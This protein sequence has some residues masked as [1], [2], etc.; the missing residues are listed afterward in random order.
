MTISPAHRT[1][2]SEELARRLA[3][4][5]RP[6]P[7]PTQSVAHAA[8]VHATAAREAREALWA[9]ARPGRLRPAKQRPAKRPFACD[10]C[11]RR[12]KT[13]EGR[14]QHKRD[15]HG[16]GGRITAASAP[17]LSKNA[18]RKAAKRFGALSE[19]E[20]RHVAARIQQ[21]ADPALIARVNALLE[22]TQV[23]PIE[24]RS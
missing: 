23:A 20:Q 5:R 16:A 3:N 6:S 15:M 21:A 11:G 9:A 7:Q 22:G 13:A 19:Q 14:A 12:L 17:T 10:N 1:L 24:V 8:E 18:R 2:T 4:R